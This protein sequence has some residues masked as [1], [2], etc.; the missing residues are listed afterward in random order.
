MK[1]RRRRNPD[2][3]WTL[4]E[5]KAANKRAGKHFFDRDTLKFFGD[6]MSNFGVR[7]EGNSMIVYL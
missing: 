7:R 2:R 1:R 5:I 6:S 4:G 3:K